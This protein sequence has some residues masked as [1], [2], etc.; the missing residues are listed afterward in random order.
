M[1]RKVCLIQGL[2]A[3]PG[4][5]AQ[6]KCC[7]FLILWLCML[8]CG[9]NISVKPAPLV[10]VCWNS[11]LI[12]CLALCFPSHITS[13]C[14]CTQIQI[15]LI[16]IWTY[17]YFVVI[18]VYRKKRRSLNF[19]TN[20]K[21]KKSHEGSSRTW[22]I[23]LV[24]KKKKYPNKWVKCFLSASTLCHY[25]FRTEKQTKSKMSFSTW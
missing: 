9:Q 22:G 5:K 16:I 1:Q 18:T 17:I 2:Q 10:K 12:C 25:T 3:Y 11:W 19:K 20:M 21:F 24:I 4:L 6:S 7:G 13:L 14:L 8:R 23:S 15:L